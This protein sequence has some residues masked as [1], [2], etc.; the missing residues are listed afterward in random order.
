MCKVLYLFKLNV[1]LTSKKAKKAR[2]KKYNLSTVL[3]FGFGK[4]KIK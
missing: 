1:I 2:K 4:Y 3:T